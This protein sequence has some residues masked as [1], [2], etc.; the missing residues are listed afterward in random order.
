MGKALDAGCGPGRTIIELASRFDQVSVLIVLQSP[1]ACRNVNTLL[2][3]IRFKLTTV[4]WTV[5]PVLVT[6]S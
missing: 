2:K 1:K 6:V 3:V 4:K 5:N